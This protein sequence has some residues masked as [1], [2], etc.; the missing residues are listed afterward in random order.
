MDKIL[1]AFI[2]LTILPNK[3]VGQTPIH[4]ILRGKVSADVHNMEGIYVI[5]LKTEK[6]TI[7]NEGG[8]FSIPATV[9]DTLVLSSIQFKGVK[10]ALSEDDFCKEL[11]FVKMMPLMTQ[12]KEVMIYQYK[13]INAVVLGIIPKGQISYTPAERRLK[14][15]TGLDARIGL[16]TSLSID[17]LFNLLSGRTA[18]LLKNVQVER[19]EYLLKRI[20]DMFDNDFYRNKLKIPEEYIKGFQYYIV[21][22]TSFVSTLNA[23]NKAMATFLMGELALKYI[24]IIANEK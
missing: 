5:N 14:A 16:N 7:T 13:N 1:I 21:E 3:M 17:P 24:D 2:V 23:N 15:A 19:K 6:S 12:L 22:N 20:G 18:E 4:R 11:F 10:I 9:G 8:Y